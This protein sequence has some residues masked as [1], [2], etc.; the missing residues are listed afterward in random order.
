MSLRPHLEV[1]KRK[2]TDYWQGPDDQPFVF[3]GVT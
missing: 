2:V 3:K 1:E